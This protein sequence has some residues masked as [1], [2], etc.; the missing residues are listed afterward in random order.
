M[1]NL[2]TSAVTRVLADNLKKTQRGLRTAGAPFID[3]SIH[4]TKVCACLVVDGAY[5]RTF[6]ASYT[7]KGWRPL[8]AMSALSGKKLYT[9]REAAEA[10]R[11]L[12]SSV[13]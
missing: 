10:V 2:E 7:A 11:A 1:A 9:D 13:P 6:V 8:P 5:V 3:V 4:R 12:F